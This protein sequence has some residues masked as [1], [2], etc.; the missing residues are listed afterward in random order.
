MIVVLVA[1]G[2]RQVAAPDRNEMRGDWLIRVPQCPDQHSGLAKSLA[3]VAHTPLQKN[4]S[5]G[6]APQSSPCC[7]LR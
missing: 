7:A 3:R 4:E 5:H 1:I 2:A 6:S